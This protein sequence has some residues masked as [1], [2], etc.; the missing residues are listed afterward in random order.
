MDA[1]HPFTI[2]NVQPTVDG[3]KYPIKREVGDRLRITATVFRDGHN[4][5]R[6]L[7]KLR[8]KYGNHSWSESPM[9]PI[10]PG[11]S[12]W[13]G[14]VVLA[15]NALYEFTIEA[16]TDIYQSWLD[17]LTKKFRAN[18]NISSDLVEGRAFLQRMSGLVTREG[19]RVYLNYVFS[20]LDQAENL[21][22]KVNIFSETD[23]V[24]LVSRNAPRD[25]STVLEP[26]LEIM[27]DREKARY[28]AW[29]EFFPRSQGRVEG[30]SATFRECMARL[31]EIKKMGFDVVYLPP[32][33][34]IGVTGR[35]GANNS[36]T[37][38][39]S[40]P[41]CPYAIGNKSGGHLA[42]EPGLGTMDD[43]LEFEKACRD[44]GLEV[45]LDFAINC[46]PDHPYVADHPE[47]F[48]KRPDGT[49][50]FA[51]NPPKKYEDIYPLNFNAPDGHWQGVWQE[52]LNIILFWAERGVRIF[53]VD[54]P[55]TKPVPFWHW[56]IR[57]IQRD[58]P[59]IIFLSEAFT[60]PPM[61]QMLAKVGFTQ[62]Y[63]YFTWR[64]FKHELTE[65][66]TELTQTSVSDYMR[67]NLFANTPDIL[68]RILQEGGRP[69]FKMRV[70]LAATLSSVY[71]IYSGYELCENTPVPGK[72]EYLNSEKYQYKVWDWDRPGNIKGYIE[73]INNI[74]RDNPALHL[75]KNLRFYK[76]ENENVLFYGKATADRRNV[77]LV[78]VN[79]DPFNRQEANI[80]IPLADMGL[81][82]GEHFEMHELISGGRFLLQGS[83]FFIKIDPAQ[84]AWIFR[85]ERWH[86]RE[87]DF[88][89]F[90]L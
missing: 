33:H 34:P 55:H 11:L 87:Q 70:A 14:S 86:Q 84:P 37:C 50:K 42:V 26:A 4:S 74:R 36:L 63:T 6:V 9:K 77:I 28:A 49:I 57:T 83:H 47:W 10:N 29:Y 5:T 23:L 54:N 41:G 82:E 24:T 32:I 76:A 75:Y 8:E 3:G 89:T 66:F 20:R 68:P 31:P 18:E 48:F 43:F 45:A 51:E 27:V 35:K 59:D 65:Y 71:G 73:K 22:S 38:G 15:K 46:S 56:L 30:R 81:K 21:E 85:V 1:N 12:L 7:L 60:K 40:E 2:E 53:R 61:M 80:S 13:A 19:E 39:P 62:S 72:E 58:H 79:L 25:D 69:A 44:L 78:L 67:G 16:F 90:G 88:D 64:N 17:D 52:M